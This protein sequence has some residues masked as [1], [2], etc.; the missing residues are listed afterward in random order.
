MFLPL[1]SVIVPC[2]HVEKY[3]NKCV[4]SIVAQTYPNLEIL[5]ID[6]GSADQT[7]ELCDAWQEKDSRIRVIHK[8]NEGLAYARKTGIENATAEYV[9]FVDADDWIDENMYF[10]MMNALLSTNSD[11]AQCGVCDAFE[12]GRIQHRSSKHKD[13]SFEIVDRIKGVLLIIEDKEWHSYLCNKVFKKHLFSHITFPKGRGLCEDVTITHTLFHHALQTVNLQAEYYFYLQR[14]GSIT[15]P[16]STASHMKNLRDAYDAYYERY[17]FAVQHPEYQTCLIYAKT[18]VISSGI[19]L[20]RDSI[21]YTQYF[22]ENFS[23]ILY[24]QLKMLQFSLKDIDKKLCTPLMRMET[25]VFFRS[26]AGYKWIVMQYAKIN[27]L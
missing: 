5:L 9:T 16:E 12:D 11:I 23:D 24:Q 1:L 20:L 7:G 3:I 13:G 2:Y 10:N 6:D 25:S 21:I 19:K 4:S 17:C 18:F 27:S 22:P 15:N 8:Q 14:T 26:P